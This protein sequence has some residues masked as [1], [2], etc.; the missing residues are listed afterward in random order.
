MEVGEEEDEEEEGKAE[1]EVG[2]ATW[3]PNSITQA[4]VLENLLRKTFN[5]SAK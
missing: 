2:N 1:E 4:L 5:P 3:S